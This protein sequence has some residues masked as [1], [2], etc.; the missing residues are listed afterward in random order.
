MLYRKL[1]STGEKVSILGLGCMHLPIINGQYNKVDTNRAISLIHKAIDNGVNYLDT[2]YPY[3]NGQSET[4][5]AEALKG[6]YR[7]KVFIADKLPSW[8]IQKRTDMD[9]YI[10]KQLER[11]QS[12]QIDFYLLH[13]VKA[14]SWS[15]LESLGVLEFLDDAVKDGRIKYTGFSFH[16]EIELFFD[17]IDSYNWDICQVQYNLCLLYTSRCV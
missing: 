12:E 4:V 10:E 9:K 14:D 7:E 17:V 2:A 1:G 6:G 8:L 3:H 15:N 16:G 5:I 13:S 11:L